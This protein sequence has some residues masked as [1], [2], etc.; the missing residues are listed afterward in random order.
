MLL[1][2]YFRG[3]E[4]HGGQVLYLKG[5]PQTRSTCA[6][7]LEAPPKSSLAD[8]VQLPATSAPSSI[9]QLCILHASLFYNSRS[10]LHLSTGTGRPYQTCRTP[11]LRT[12]EM[13]PLTHADWKTVISPPVLR[14]PTP[15][16][17]KLDQHQI[18]TCVVSVAMCSLDF[19][20]MDS[21]G[22]LLPSH[23]F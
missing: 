5:M 9:I 11:A 1:S 12:F 23:G 13:D 20:V 19:P 16:L 2:W 6:F 22:D 18:M 21:Q 15:V 14:F 17:G 8:L 3:C 7:P 4:S 10:N